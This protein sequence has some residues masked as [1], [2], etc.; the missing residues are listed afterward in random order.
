MGPLGVSFLDPDGSIGMDRDA[1]GLPAAPLSPR[2]ATVAPAALH[3]GTARLT[4]GHRR[5]R[6]PRASRSERGYLSVVDS[7]PP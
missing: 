2:G 1:Q 6:A 3:A 5:G 4:V 7:L